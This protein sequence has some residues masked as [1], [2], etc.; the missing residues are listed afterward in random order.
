ML[1]ESEHLGQPESGVFLI[2]DSSVKENDDESIDVDIMYEVLM[3]CLFETPNRLGL[4]LASLDDDA[5]TNTIDNESSA[6]FMQIE[7]E[8]I[9]TEWENKTKKKK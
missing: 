8:S 6:E 2:V 7:Q 1:A 3:G 9:R 5:S 4:R